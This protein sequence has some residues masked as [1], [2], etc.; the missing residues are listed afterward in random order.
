[1][2]KKNR[3]LLRAHHLLGSVL[4]EADKVKAAYM[5]GVSGRQMYE[6]TKELIRLTRSQPDLE[7]EVTDSFDEI[8]AACPRGPNKVPYVPPRSTFTFVEARNPWY[9]ARKKYGVWDKP[10]SEEKEREG[11]RRCS[12]EELG[13]PI[14]T[15]ITAR[16]AIKIGELW[17]KYI[18]KLQIPLM[19]N[20]EDSQRELREDL[21]SFYDSE[22]IPYKFFPP[23]KNS[24]RDLR[25]V[26]KSI[27]DEKK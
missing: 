18:G 26:L 9:W 11:D 8:C 20:V 3:I 10:C 19:Q 25:A 22:N 13:L 7:V 21:E 5:K 12:R 15:V 17:E 14:G 1:M 4:M 23:T 27:L 6:H 2:E 16:Q 24:A